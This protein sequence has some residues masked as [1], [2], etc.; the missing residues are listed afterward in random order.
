MSAHYLSG[1]ENNNKIFFYGNNNKIYTT[2]LKP[3][4]LY[5]KFGSTLHNQPDPYVRTTKHA[6]T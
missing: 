6:Q 3:N 4:G 2:H 1:S 5:S